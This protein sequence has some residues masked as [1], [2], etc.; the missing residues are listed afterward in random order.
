M[1]ISNL[2]SN[3]TKQNIKIYHVFWVNFLASW[4]SSFPAYNNTVY[5]SDYRR[6]LDRYLPS[7][8][9]SYS[10]AQVHAESVSK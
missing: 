5:V 2:T 1:S 9:A 6:L 3:K 7:S 4:P 10:S 8:V